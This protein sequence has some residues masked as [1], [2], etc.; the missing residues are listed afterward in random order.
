MAGDRRNYECAYD[1]SSR[2]VY[3]EEAWFACFLL[4]YKRLTLPFL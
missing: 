4:N 2:Q 1:R 3:M